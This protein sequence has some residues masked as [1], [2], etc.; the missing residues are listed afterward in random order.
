MN[1]D[2]FEFIEYRMSIIDGLVRK[3]AVYRERPI[4]VTGKFIGF[5]E[6]DFDEIDQFQDSWTEEEK[7]LYNPNH[8]NLKR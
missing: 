1:E 4:V 8:N 5:K 6:I 2:H 3:I 7:E